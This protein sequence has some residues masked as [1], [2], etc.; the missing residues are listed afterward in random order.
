MVKITTLV[1]KSGRLGVDA[2]ML[3]LDSSTVSALWKEG[4]RLALAKAKQH[5]EEH[6]SPWHVHRSDVSLP[7]TAEGEKKKSLQRSHTSPSLL[8]SRAAK[9]PR[10]SL[11][12]LRSNSPPVTR[13]RRRSSLSGVEITAAL[14]AL[15]RVRRKQ[16]VKFKPGDRAASALANSINSVPTAQLD[17]CSGKNR[18]SSSQ[19]AAKKNSSTRRLVF[20]QWLYLESSEFNAEVNEAATADEAAHRLRYIDCVWGV[21]NEHYCIGPDDCPTLAALRLYSD[22]NVTGVGE[23]KQTWATAQQV[24][25]HI[26][27]M[28]SCN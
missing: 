21:A 10:G 19:S 7:D 18:A 20:R 16:T 28:I 11:A 25:L 13:R 24:S 26:Y 27:F 15:T 6:T 12:L 2:D 14:G 23:M 9:Q 4:D 17:P 8:G 22:F 3:E 1:R 5:E